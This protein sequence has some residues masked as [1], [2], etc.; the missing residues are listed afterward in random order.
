MPDFPE[1]YDKEVEWA[2]WPSDVAE[3]SREVFERC[4]RGSRFTLEDIAAEAGAE[5][6]AR[7]V[8]LDP[9]QAV[10]TI[11]AARDAL[12]VLNE[13][14]ESLGLLDSSQSAPA[15]EAASAD[16]ETPSADIEVASETEA[17]DEA[18]A[19]AVEAAPEE[20]EATGAEENAEVVADAEFSAPEENGE[21]APSGSDDD[22]RSIG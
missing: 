22:D 12:A 17:A 9:T 15:V 5:E 1:G 10:Q 11:Y 6:F 18:E 4:V 19:E 8:G 7:A 3:L 13:A 2:R 16:E 14:A 20:A 21:P